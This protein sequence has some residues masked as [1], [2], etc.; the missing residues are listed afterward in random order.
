MLLHIWPDSQGAELRMPANKVY[1]AYMTAFRF[2]SV[3]GYK[4]YVKGLQIMFTR[5]KIIMGLQIMFT[6]LV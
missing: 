4:V 5:L 6:L 1:V 2:S 3:I